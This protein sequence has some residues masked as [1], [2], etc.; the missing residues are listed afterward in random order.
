[1]KTYHFLNQNQTD[2]FVS[3]FAKSM[4]PENIILLNGDLGTGKTYI[5]S[6][7]A[8]YFGIKDL[9]SS[10]FQRVNFHRGKM[11]LIHCDFY[12]NSCDDYFFLNEIEPLLLYP[13]I[14]LLEWMKPEDFIIDYGQVTEI[15]IQHKGDSKREL[16][17]TKF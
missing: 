16:R 11:N 12:R 17:I 1:M 10:S 6:K 3:E 9:S 8:N 13:W 5:C 7:I 14:L 2:V 4:N 15:F